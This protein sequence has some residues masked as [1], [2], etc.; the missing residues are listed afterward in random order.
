M[1]GDTGKRRQVERRDA[2]EKRHQQARR[3]NRERD[4][5]KETGDRQHGAARENKAHDVA[6]CRAERLP[7]AELTAALHGL[8]DDAIDADDGEKQRDQPE[9]RNERQRQA[10]RAMAAPATAS[11]GLTLASGSSES[12][13]RTARRSG[14]TIA[15]L[16]KSDRTIGSRA[17]VTR[18]ASGC[19]K[20]SAGSAV[21]M[22]RRISHVA[23][24][25]SHGS[26]R[27]PELR[28]RT[29]GRFGTRP[30]LSR[31]SLV[32][33]HDRRRFGRVGSARFPSSHERCA[34]CFRVIRGEEVIA[35]LRFVP[36]G[37]WPSDDFKAGVLVVVRS[38][39]N[40]S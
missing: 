30:I 25:T 13:S 37:G 19:G 26:L 23:D 35:R 8:R 36:G 28:P 27:A 33:Q 22:P 4:P 9:R 31:R 29:D 39:A 3:D 38:T 7:D 14:S 17:R 12:S 32:Q 5:A 34:H 16:G 18:T 20:Y 21:E 11:S 40:R 6:A 10:A 15:S 2:V 1:S 24:D